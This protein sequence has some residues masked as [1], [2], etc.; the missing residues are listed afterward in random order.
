MIDGI[1]KAGADFQSLSESIDTTTVGGRLIFHVMGAL[2]KFERALIGERTKA[3]IQAAARRG[4][5][6]GR[7]RKLLA[8]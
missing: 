2:A 1:G 8:H 7:P 3:G 4:K 5:A 6:V